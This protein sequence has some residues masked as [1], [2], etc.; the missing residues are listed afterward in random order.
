MLAGLSQAELARRAKTRQ[1]VISAI[2]HNELRPGREL[3][4]RLAAALGV[5]EDFLAINE[6]GE[7]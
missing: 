7:L 5:P 3:R 4:G 2:E 1:P 6:E